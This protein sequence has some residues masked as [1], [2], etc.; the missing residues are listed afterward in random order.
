MSGDLPDIKEIKRLIDSSHKNADDDKLQELTLQ[1]CF[2]YI[3]NIPPENHLFCDQNCYYPAVHSLIL[4]SFPDSDALEWY[5]GKIAS[6]LNSCQKCIY[7]FNIGKALLRNKFLVQRNLQPESVK[8]FS[9]LISQWE[10]SRLLPILSNASQ[11]IH[12]RRSNSYLTEFTLENKIIMAIIECLNGPGMLRVVPQLKLDFSNTFDY[13]LANESLPFTFNN[14][15]LPSSVLYFL[16]EGTQTEKK[17]AASTIKGMYQFTKMMPLDFHAALEEEYEQHFYNIQSPNF[18]N[19]SNCVYFW[20]NMTPLL[21]YCDKEVIIEKLQSPANMEYMKKFLSF[22]LVPLINV[23]TNQIMSYQQTPLPFM[24]RA[25]DLLVS[26]LKSDYWKYIQPLI[27]KNY[28]DTIFSNPYFLHYLLTLH[29]D[30]TEKDFEP[31]STLNDMLS[32]VHPM[33]TLLLGSQKQQAV[34]MISNFFIKMVADDQIALP[35]FTKNLLIS[36]SCDMLIKFLTIDHNSFTL[37]VASDLLGKLETKSLVDKHSDIFIKFAF[38]GIDYQANK[39]D[40]ENFSFIQSSCLQLI[41]KCFQFD[42][43]NFAHYS[44][45]SYFSV[46]SSLAPFSKLLWEKVVKQ[47]LKMRADHPNQINSI[48]WMLSSLSNVSTILKTKRS[49]NS[50]SKPIVIDLTDRLGIEDSCDEIIGYINSLLSMILDVDPNFIKAALKDKKSMDG[51]WSCLLSAEQEITQSATSILYE[52]YD[53]SGRYEGIQAVLKDNFENCLSSLI[54]ALRNLIR[55]GY[56]EPCPK[57]VRI[58]MDVINALNDPIDGL[59]IQSNKLNVDLESSRKILQEFWNQCWNFLVHIYKKT[60][61]WS[62]DYH[63]S[64]LVEYTRDTLDLSHSTLNSLKGFAGYIN[65]DASASLD[66]TKELFQKIMSSFQ[67]MMVWLRLSDTALL[68]LCVD[69]IFRTI[70]LAAELKL[71]FPDNVVEYLVRYSIVAKKFKNKLDVNQRSEILS[72]AR[73]LNEALVEKILTEDQ[74]QT[75]VTNLKLKSRSEEPKMDRQIS[76]LDRLRSELKSSRSTSGTP[77][78]IHPPSKSGFHSKRLR[79]VSDES[80]DSDSEKSSTG[81]NELFGKKQKDKITLLEKMSTKTSIYTKKVNLIDEQR[82]REMNM[83]KRLNVN[84]DPLYKTILGWSYTDKGYI[85][86]G[87]SMEDYSIV[88]DVFKDSKQYQSVFLNLLFLEA[89][90][91]IVQ[92]RELVSNRPFSMLVGSRSS[93]DSFFDIYASVKKSVLEEHKIGESDLLVLAVSIDGSVNAENINPKS[94]ENNNINC[95]AKVREIKSAN[96]E[97]ADITFRIS[98]RQNPMVPLLSPQADILAMKVLQMTTIEREYSSLMGLPYYDLLSSILKAKPSYDNIEDESLFDD[99]IKVYNVNKS[100]ARAIY[101]SVHNK[102]F[103]LIQGPP[104]TGKTKTILGIVGYLLT[105]TNSNTINIPLKTLNFDKKKKILICAPSNAAVDE[106]VLR[107]RSSCKNGRGETFNPKVVRL[108]RSDAI[109]NAVK[110]LTL[111][112]LVEK[113]LGSRDSSKPVVD[114]SIREKLNKCLDERDKIRKELNSDSISEEKVISLQFKL[115]EITKTKNELGRKLDEQRENASIS[116]RNKELDKRNIQFKILNE[117]NIICSTLSGSAHE[118]VRSMNMSCDTVI[119]DEACQCTELSAIIPL[120]Y[121]F[122]RCIMVGDPNQLPPTVLSQTAASFNYDQS[123]FVRM[124]KNHPE[125][126]YLLNVQYRMHPHISEFPSEEFYNSR[127]VDGPDMERINTRFWHE[128]YPL[129]PYRFFNV[130]GKQELSARSKSFFNITEAN[131]ALELVKHLEKLTTQ[132][133]ISLDGKIGVISPY[134]EQIYKLKNIFV[135]FFGKPILDVIDFNTIDG[136]QG[137]EKEIIII[138]LVRANGV[139]FLNDIRRMNV[140]L[141]RA[142]TTLW[143]LG[144]TESLSSSRVWKDLIDNAE[145]RNLVTKAYPGFLNSELVKPQPKSQKREKK[146]LVEEKL[147]KKENDNEKMKNN[148]DKWKEQE[149]SSN[150]LTPNSLP[151]KP[152]A[153][154]GAKIEKAKNTSDKK[155]SS[156]ALNTGLPS[157]KHSN[158]FTKPRKGVKKPKQMPTIYNNNNNKVPL[159]SVIPVPKRTGTIPNPKNSNTSPSVSG[160]QVNNNTGISCSTFSNE[161]MNNPYP[162]NADHQSNGRFHPNPTRLNNNEFNGNSNGGNF[163]RFSNNSQN[164]FS[165]PGPTNYYSSGPSRND[166][167]QNRY[168]ETRFS[169]NDRN[170]NP[171][172]ANYNKVPGNFNF[173]NNPN[174]IR[175]SGESFNGNKKNLNKNSSGNFSLGNTNNNGNYYGN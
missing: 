115:R 80:D 132:K 169:Q 36:L 18:Y 47:S 70:D 158:L 126:I 78:V 108:G 17:W 38:D 31:H 40:L 20:N 27:F 56:F 128:K 12:Q 72:R 172:R 55:S 112:E 2:E 69:L 13:L 76:K 4:F 29:N 32:W 10:A 54:T 66:V 58:L 91:A 149:A 175:G 139:G 28:L 25:F 94:L 171:N 105:E 65:K 95:L 120:R 6:Y 111:E 107:L 15:K 121:G 133:N 19:D 142:R 122:E 74:S 5:K 113:Q 52:A 63:V 35:S 98:P 144:S 153:A 135:R 8:K 92:A 81:F 148:S 173:D 100:Q 46:E 90:Q 99:M 67:P 22:K 170:K 14:N 84:I 64:D 50:S 57:T 3:S 127:L 87:F 11:L 97:F 96:A 21:S 43:L 71:K 168:E 62:M 60:I 174:G 134:K 44:F 104:G 37:N 93:V 129:S 89:W 118:F 163:N 48:S 114:N 156:S 53:S 137:Q 83:R 68:T 1:K 130:A 154:E 140:G 150:L 146:K 75:V 49:K 145:S 24:L 79:R 102:G 159:S 73:T 166:S 119:I 23:L 103:S 39:Q 155:R 131:I 61:D 160:K 33:L 88:E 143:I 85:P 45:D 164:R 157:K 34:S 42:I 124:Q 26:K 9:E 7:M 51:L 109:N 125:S 162:S 138:S 101:G 161:A 152:T 147:K 167:D 82:K 86:S 110:D 16:F 41:M 117:A 151:N 136:F 123:L 77:T 116:Y 59:L 165:S 141:T 30:T 106:L